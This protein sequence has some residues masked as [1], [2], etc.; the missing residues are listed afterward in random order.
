[1]PDKTRFTVLAPVIRGQ[2]G[3]WR[4]LFEDLLKQGF[5]R[6]RVDGETH[7]LSDNLQLDRRMRHNI[8]VVVDRLAI[9]SGLRT[10]LAGVGRA[11]EDRQRLVDRGG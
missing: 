7:S 1:M 2:K 10:Q 6:A 5:V 9:K 3:E 11:G 4:D 8:E